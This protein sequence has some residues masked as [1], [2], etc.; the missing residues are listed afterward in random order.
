MSAA[1]IYLDYHA[2]APVDPLAFEAMRPYFTE[3]FGDPGQ[4]LHAHGWTADEAMS[5]FA[6]SPFLLRS[7]A[8]S[9]P[10]L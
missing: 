4:T 7:S 3:R 6:G 5:R 10:T 8:H 1:P 9:M 2:A